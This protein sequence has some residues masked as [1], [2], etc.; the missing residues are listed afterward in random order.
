MVT[1][2]SF[3]RPARGAWASDL[4]S[5]AHHLQ[6]AGRVDVQQ[7]DTGK[8]GG[9]ADRTGDGIGDIVKLEVQKHAG[10]QGG[11]LTDRFGS[12]RSEEMNVDLEHP[13]QVSQRPGK[14]DCFI[15]AAEVQRHDELTA[16]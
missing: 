3:G 5:G 13:D 12:G 10:A 1:A 4:G 6:A 2:S 8:A 15:E 14:S 16:G 11:D 7:L 9:S